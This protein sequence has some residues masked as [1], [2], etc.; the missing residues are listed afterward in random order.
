MQKSYQSFYDLN[1]VSAEVDHCFA[2]AVVIRNMNSNLCWIV[3]PPHRKYFAGSYCRDG[4]R[5][6]L[7][8]LLHVPFL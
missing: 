8:A 6:P 5:I 1:L 4:L 3:L 2:A 7:A